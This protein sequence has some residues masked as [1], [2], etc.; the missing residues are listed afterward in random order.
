MKQKPMP[1]WRENV[2][3]PASR[4]AASAPRKMP[5]T[6][7]HEQPAELGRPEVQVHGQQ[8]RRGR[9][10]QEQAGEV[11]ARRSPDFMW[12]SG[13]AEDVA[14]SCARGSAG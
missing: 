7:G 12:N 4:L 9:D 5:L 6:G 1:I 14:G 10:E 2:I 8:H 13:G 11:E 3:L